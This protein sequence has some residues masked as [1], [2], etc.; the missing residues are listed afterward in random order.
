M[1]PSDWRPPPDQVTGPD[2]LPPGALDELALM[3]GERV[4]RC[5]RL[6]HGYLVLTNL[7]C[8]ALARRAEL[9]AP[10][11]WRIDS[12]YF[13][14]ALDHPR[15]LAD[16]FLELREVGDGGGAASRLLVPN[17]RTVSSEIDAAIPAGRA[18]WGRRRERAAADRAG[19]VARAA[20]DGPGVVRE[21]IREVIKV[22]CRYC[23][24]LMDEGAET[25]PYCGAPQR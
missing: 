22:R 19:R 20:T 15:V 1:S 18:E 6:A 4:A 10:P 7:R 17:A 14:Y 23:G 12:S 24:N 13:F 5:W 2:Q 21:V 11:H 25:C 8:A 3:D 16:R 9:L